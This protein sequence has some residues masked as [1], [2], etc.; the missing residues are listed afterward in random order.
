MLSSNVN[1]LEAWRWLMNQQINVLLP[2]VPWRCWLGVRKSIRPVNKTSDKE[3]TWLTV[4][5]GVRCNWFAYRPADTTATPSTLALLKSRKDLY[6]SAALPRLSWK[7]AAN[8]LLC[9]CCCWNHVCH[10]YKKLEGFSRAHT[11]PTHLG[12]WPWHSKI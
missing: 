2:S 4:W 5:T 7:K 8:W 10:I 11:S 3:L 9:C 1:I 6:L 12:L